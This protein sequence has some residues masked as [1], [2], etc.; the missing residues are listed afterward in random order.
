MSMSPCCLFDLF[1]AKRNTVM[2]QLRH[3]RIVKC[4]SLFWGKIVTGIGKL[5]QVCDEV[6]HHSKDSFYVTH[7]LYYCGFPI[8]FVFC[9][10]LNRNIHKEFRWSIW[11]I[12]KQYLMICLRSIKKYSRWEDRQA[13]IKIWLKKLCK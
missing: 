7:F 3:Q 11:F 4:R 2:W 10:L 9:R 6:F 1:S 13:S 12:S 8:R 5:F